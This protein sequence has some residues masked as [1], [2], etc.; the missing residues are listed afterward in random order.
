MG[1][2][3][4]AHCSSVYKSIFCELESQALS[5]VDE[6]KNNLK[7]SKGK[8]LFN[9][10]DKV[11]GVYCIKSG[12]AK[13]IISDSAGNESIAKILGPGSILG[14]RILFSEIDHL[15][16]VEFLEEASVCFIESSNFLNLIKKN[17]SLALTIGHRLANE[18]VESD[19]KNLAL[20]HHSV[21]ER[22]C[23][24]ILNL[25]QNYGIKTSHGIELDIRLTREEMASM[26][27]T[28]TETMIRTISGLKDDQIITQEGKKII[29]T[30]LE[31]LTVCTGMY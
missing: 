10:G 24:L 8:F 30:N 3:N 20:V 11:K 12:M 16:T 31:L 13:A 6:V 1:K 2:Q 26:V 4:C 23:A 9:Q 5:Q 19:N 21:K 22:V 27:G 17:P 7:F 29:I 18:L 25:S 28:T 15:A 14:H